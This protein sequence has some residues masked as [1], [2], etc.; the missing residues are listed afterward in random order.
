MFSFKIIP[1][2]IMP[3]FPFM[4]FP[5]CTYNVFDNFIVLIFLAISHPIPV[6]TILLPLKDR[7]DERLEIPTCLPK[8][9][10]PAAS[11][12]ISNLFL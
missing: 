8:E 5:R 11:S 6:V 1:E 12:I 7:I 9:P 10:T 4:Y 2:S 3:H